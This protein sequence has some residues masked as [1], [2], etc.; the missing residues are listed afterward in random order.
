MKGPRFE[1]AVWGNDRYAVIDTLQRSNTWIFLVDNH[2]NYQAYG[3]ALDLCMALNEI[4]TEL[5]P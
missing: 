5:W 2:D 1:V 3:K 4:P